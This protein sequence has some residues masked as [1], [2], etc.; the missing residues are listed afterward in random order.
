MNYKTR[1]RSK[2]NISAAGGIA[3]GFS[4]GACESEI[5]SAAGGIAAGF[6][7]GAG[8][9][10]ITNLNFPANSLMGVSFFPYNLYMCLYLILKTT[11]K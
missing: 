3:A 5:I 9:G 7:T 4:T 2:E 11:Q 1:A 8:A 10:A 6:S